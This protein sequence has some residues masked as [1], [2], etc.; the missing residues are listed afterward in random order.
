MTATSTPT[1]FGRQ[2]GQKL[3]IGLGNVEFGRERDCASQ[4]VA[5][6]L[7][8]GPAQNFRSRYTDSKYLRREQMRHA[9]VG[10]PDR[11][12]S[13]VSDCRPRWSETLRPGHQTDGVPGVLEPPASPPVRCNSLP[14]RVPHVPSTPAARGPRVPP[15]RAPREQGRTFVIRGEPLYGMVVVKTGLASGPMCRSIRGALARR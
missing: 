1:L 14:P 5:P 7:C 12:E 4:Y 9:S 11:V 6:R 3:L 10:L 13:R 2:R 8:G 15:S